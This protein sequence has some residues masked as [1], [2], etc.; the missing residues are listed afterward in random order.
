MRLSLN[1]CC[2]SYSKYYRKCGS[3]RMKNQ[4]HYG[5]KISVDPKTHYYFVNLS[6][7]KSGFK[8]VDN[9]LLKT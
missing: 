5:D 4:V 9:C 7:A 1:R 2:T 8:T 3:S 6:C